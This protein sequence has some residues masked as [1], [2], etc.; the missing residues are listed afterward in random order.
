MTYSI[1]VKLRQIKISNDLRKDILRTEHFETHRGIDFYAF[2]KSKDGFHFAISLTISKR[3]ILAN[4]GKHVNRQYWNQ[5]TFAVDDEKHA[6]AY[7]NGAKEMCQYG[8]TSVSLSSR[9]TNFFKVGY[10][11]DTNSFTKMFVDDFA[12]WQ[13]TFTDEEARSLYD[14][15]K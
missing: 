2:Q 7:V 10:Y 12:V 13:S 6:C 4:F 5:F 8:S 15:S 3:W 9:G 14:V 11:N 1:W